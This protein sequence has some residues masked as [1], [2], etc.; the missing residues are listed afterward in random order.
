MTYIR[1]CMY[2]C[3]LEILDAL[4]YTYTC[5]DCNEYSLYVVNNFSF[6]ISTKFCLPL[7]FKIYFSNIRISKF[8]QENIIETEVA[9]AKF[10]SDF[11]NRGIIK[12][13]FYL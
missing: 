8:V 2:K 13:F 4:K 6:Q 11:R 1:E 5:I 9:R 3:A 7:L 12:N 10:F